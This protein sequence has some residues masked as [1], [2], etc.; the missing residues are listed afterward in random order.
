[1][2]LSLVNTSRYGGAERALTCRLGRGAETCVAVSKFVIS[3]SRAVRQ[4]CKGCS[5]VY[6]VGRPAREFGEKTA[7]EGGNEDTK[8]GTRGKEE[9]G[10]MPVEGDE[11]VEEEWDEQ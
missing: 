11:A 10:Q 7:F 9:I 6:E 4:S 8:V 3:T 2:S 5:V 1:M